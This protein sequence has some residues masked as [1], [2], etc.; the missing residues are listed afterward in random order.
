[1]YL[2]YQ[3]A[4]SGQWV[5]AAPTSA[6]VTDIK[7]IDDLTPQFNHS[8]TTFN[9]LSSGQAVFPVS[10]QQ[11]L[12]SVESVILSPGVDYTVQGSQITFTAAP[13]SSDIFFGVIYGTST[14]LNT[15]SDNS[16]N[17]AKLQNL[18]VTPSKLNLNAHVLPAQDNAYNLGSE[19]LRFANLYTGDL[20]LKNERGD[21]TLIEEAEYLSLRNNKTGK[22]YQLQ[23]LEINEEEV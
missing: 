16:I 7:I 14:V 10:A 19:A 11:L 22:R 6:G 12:I 1:M 13:K 4:D 9:L 21:W 8:T 2:Y 23:M 20:H 18:A 15:V 5:D 17:T 3:D